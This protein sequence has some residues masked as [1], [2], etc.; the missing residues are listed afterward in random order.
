MSYNI[1]LHLYLCEWIWRHQLS[2][3]H[4]RLHCEFCCLREWG[5][6]SG[7]LSMWITTC[8]TTIHCVINNWLVLWIYFPIL[9]S[10]MVSTATLVSVLLGSL[11]ADVKPTLMNASQTHARMEGIALWATHSVSSL[12]LAKSTWWH[13][14]G[15]TMMSSCTLDLA[16]C[17][18]GAIKG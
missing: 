15:I 16:K 3:Q 5:N 2:D 13:C 9:S 7:K 17:D 10:R 14:G 1:S 11:E 4:Q 12:Y 8:N 6:M 18:D